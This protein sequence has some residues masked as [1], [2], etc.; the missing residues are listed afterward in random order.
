[1]RW[2][3]NN[4]QFLQYMDYID[5]LGGIF[6]HRFVSPLVSGLVCRSLFSY[7]VDLI[8]W[9]EQVTIPKALSM[10]ADFDDLYVIGSKLISLI[11]NEHKLSSEPAC[12]DIRKAYSC[13]FEVDQ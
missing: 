1:M 7:A 13:C 9:A 12:P 3:Y 10:F 2:F 4:R 11:H 8:R 5:H 6:W